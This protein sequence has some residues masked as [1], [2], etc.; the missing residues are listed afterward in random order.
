MSS[1]RRGALSSLLTL[2]LAAGVVGGAAAPAKAETLEPITGAGSTWSQNAVD[3]W[4]RTVQDD[5]SMSVNYN[6]LGSSAG[7]REFIDQTVDFAV[8][9]L[10]FQS[11]PEDGSPPEV[12]TSGYTYLP[13]V[14]GGTAFMYNLRID[15]HGVTDLRLSGEVI[16]K[17]FTNVITNWNDPA[18]Q[19]DNPSLAL[20]DKAITP[21]VRA[22]GSGSTAQFT[23]WMARQHPTLWQAYSGRSGA[24]AQ[25]PVKGSMRA[26]SGS[27]GVSGYVSQ[28]YGEGAITY[29]ENSYA[30]NSGLP[31]AK[32]LNAAGYYVAPTADAVSI[33]LLAAGINTDEQSSSYGTLQ[34][35]GVYTDTDPRAYPLSSASYLIV[36][37]E[38][39]RVFTQRKGTTLGAFGAFA[40]CAG[41]QRAAFFGYAPL[42]IN[43]V[44]NSLNQLAKVPGAQRT[45]LDGCSNPTF[46]AGDSPSDTV[47]TRTAPMPPETDRLGGP[48]PEACTSATPSSG[49]VVLCAQTIAA[50]DSPL[51]LELPV[52]ATA[53]FAAPTL[54]DGQSLTVGDLPPITVKDGRRGDAPGWDL[55]ASIADFENVQLA[56]VSIPKQF[57]GL[58]PA[59]GGSID[60]GITAGP[61]EVAGR[62]VYPTVFA[63]AVAGTGLGDTELG[64]TVSLLSPRD[65]PAGTYRSTMTL[66][67][68]SR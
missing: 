51:S 16:T 6:G 12:P 31:V 44:D 25:Y 18:I 39:N 22:D 15:G 59:L 33:A 68:V 9:E 45:S 61:G 24:T 27:L 46:A 26:Q 14:A 48:L 47:L 49:S 32:V 28:S 19:A 56:G 5:Y 29:V 4:R 37:T 50:V 66:T 21:V 8:S 40:L 17:I 52:D 3:Q 65:R 34:L 23:D 58:R 20:P 35:D 60:P 38:T 41:Q 67:L 57:A 55:V 62:A 54:Q 13:I 36:P 1:T 63:S 53:A 30:V 10:P 64:G 43:L 2:L 11:N 7:R 42:P